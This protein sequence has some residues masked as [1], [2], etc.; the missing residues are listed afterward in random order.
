MK[1]HAIAKGDFGSTSG[2]SDQFAAD[3]SKPN[4]KDSRRKEL[5][6]RLPPLFSP[7][8]PDSPRLFEESKA[9]KMPVNPRIIRSE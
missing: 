7:P 4:G 3:F 1:L 2:R 5:T 9:N 8:T 6:G